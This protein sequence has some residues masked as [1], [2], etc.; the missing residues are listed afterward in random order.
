MQKILNTTKYV[1]DMLP[2]AKHCRK[3]D[4]R[5]LGTLAHLSHFKLAQLA[6]KQ[7]LSP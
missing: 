6:G 7:P 2:A 1:T 5:P 4:P 3:A